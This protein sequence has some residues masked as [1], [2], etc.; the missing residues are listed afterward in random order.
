MARVISVVNCE[1]Q[2]LYDIDVETH[3][4]FA[5]GQGVY[6]H[7]SELHDIQTTRWDDGLTIHTDASQAEVRVMARMAE[8]DSLLQAYRD[9]A[10]IHRYIAAEALGKSPD[11]VT[12]EERRFS[13]M[14]T[15][16]ILYGSTIYSCAQSF[17]KGDIQ[18]TQ[19]LFD[20]FYRRFPKVR[21]YIDKCHISAIERGF[22]E[23]LFGDRLYI[24]A[25][26]ADKFSDDRYLRGEFDARMREAQN[27]P[28]QCVKF[29]TKIPLFDGSHPE[30]KDIEGKTVWVYSVDHKNNCIK[31]GRGRVFKSGSTDTMYKITLDNGES[32]ETTD[33]HLWMKRD[34]S[35]TRADELDVGD[36][37]M[38]LYRNISSIKSGNDLEGYEMSYNPFNLFWEYTHR[39][40]DTLLNGEGTLRHHIDFNKLNNSPENL[41]LMTWKTHSKL[42]QDHCR[43]T[44]GSEDAM[45]K[46]KEWWNTPEGLNYKEELSESMKLKNQDKKEKYPD[47]YQNQIDFVK[48]D[49]SRRLVETGNVLGVSHSEYRKIVRDSWKSSKEYRIQRLK[50][51]H[52]SEKAIKNH[53]VA[54]KKRERSSRY[55]VSRVMKIIK[56]MNELNLKYTTP[57]LYDKNIY[58]IPRIILSKFSRRF[59]SYILDV[60]T[61]E[62]FLSEINYRNHKIISIE[63]IKYEDPIDLY[64]IEVEKYHNFAIG[65]NGVFIHNS[66]SSTLIA[67]GLYN[68]SHLLHS[69]EIEHGLFGFTHDSGDFDLHC[70]D[71]LKVLH[72]ERTAIEDDLSEE[73][74]VPLVMDYAIGVR[75]DSMLELDIKEVSEDHLLAEFKG[76]EES[77]LEIKDRFELSG[78]KAKLELTGEAKPKLHSLGSLFQNSRAYSWHIGKV[79]PH[80]KGTMELIS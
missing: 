50:E 45:R 29:D 41:R 42:H 72:A 17:M 80:V 69:N 60:M 24:E 57:E 70:Q 66:S 30:I 47:W 61:W 62:E 19:D 26:G 38:P 71:L 55:R 40:D 12:E 51:S 78:I 46:S 67:L 34:G 21:E 1:P 11:K 25:N 65:E 77:F 4:N 27:W 16:A 15:F 44:F 22:V 39:L 54:S 31:P 9:G 35:Y 2:Y 64:D 5:I 36:S 14:R 13:K 49:I 63:V 6:A 20:G 28:I 56:Y 74:G 43:R 59:S 52:N 53:K 58:L 48:E 8:E 18:A 7:N 37:L 3:H 10:D 75:G 79:I 68:M 73:Y 32:F 23:T 33:F 76:T